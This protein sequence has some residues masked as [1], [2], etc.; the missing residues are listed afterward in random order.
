MIDSFRISQKEISVLE[1]KK[2]EA[3]KE[4]M[5]AS[6]ESSIYEHR[7]STLSEMIPLELERKIHLEDL[8]ERE[9]RDIETLQ[10]TKDN[11]LEGK[12]Y[13]FITDDLLFVK[14]L[15]LLPFRC[16]SHKK[17]NRKNVLI[18]ISDSSL[19]N[20]TIYLNWIFS[21]NRL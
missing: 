7:L 5:K 9:K 20:S 6:K 2:A 11:M 15:N 3:M 17:V 10:K 16:N 21:P 1:S 19:I 14:T 18:Q 4:Y 13:C 12:L 8:L